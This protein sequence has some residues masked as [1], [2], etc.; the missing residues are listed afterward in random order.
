MGSPPQGREPHITTLSRENAAVQCGK[1]D[2]RM[3]EMGHSRRFER[4][5]D[6]T[7]SPP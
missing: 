1:I 2:R 7:A 5:V 6:M 4:E 3:A